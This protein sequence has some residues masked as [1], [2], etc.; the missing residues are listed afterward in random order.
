MKS[1]LLALAF[2]SAPLAAFALDVGSSGFRWSSDLMNEGFRPIASSGVVNDIYG[3]SRG[4][5]IYLC[6]V[7]DTAEHQ[8]FRQGILRA[9]LANGNPAPAMPNIPVACIL[10][11]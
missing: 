9:E 4:T 7:A 5:D 10:T 8:T 2:M 3:M 11:Q 1:A 6:F